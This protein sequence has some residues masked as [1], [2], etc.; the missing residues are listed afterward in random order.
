MLSIA[1]A[2]LEALGIVYEMA[3]EM[4]QFQYRHWA[5][6]PELTKYLKRVRKESGV[7]LR[8]LLVA[9]A[10]KSGAPHYH[11]LIHEA[12]L[13]PV[14]HAVLS[15]QWKLGFSKYNLVKD[16]RAAFYVT[17]YLAKSALARVR[18]S[19]GYGQAVCDLHPSLVAPRREKIMTSF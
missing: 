17:K 14:R 4:E 19:Q 3:S 2:R 9:E 7:K 10:H 15:R 18:A 6:C 5:I 12:G 13:A 16:N 8:Y 11:L 1:R